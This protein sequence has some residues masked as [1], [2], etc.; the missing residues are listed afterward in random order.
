M[1]ENIE[2]NFVRKEIKKQR[3]GKGKMKEV[4]IIE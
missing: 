1:N 3:L 4:L 2:E